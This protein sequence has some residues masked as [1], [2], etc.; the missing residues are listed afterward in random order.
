VQKN[1]KAGATLELF[2]ARAKSGDGPPANSPLTTQWYDLSGAANHG[3]LQ[4]FAGNGGSGWATGPDRLIFDG[5][6]DY[7][8]LPDTGVCEDRVFSHELWIYGFT[9]TSTVY[10]TS[11][12]SN[13]STANYAGLRF[14]SGK[15]YFRMADSVAAKMAGG[16]YT[17]NDGALHHIVGTVDGS[18]VRCYVDGQL[19]ATTD[20][21]PSNNLVVDRA[22]VGALSRD[23]VGS[24]FPGAICVVRF[25]PITLEAVH[26]ARNY[27]IGLA[28]PGLELLGRIG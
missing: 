8:S 5:A 24:Y 17:V 25:Y 1:S 12:G 22:A 15:A 10:A 27:A 4:T 9:S 2:A 6:S 3:T 7:V 19:G 16:D 28:W 21:A 18:T 14:A 13:S 11:E 26:I 23:V 20:A